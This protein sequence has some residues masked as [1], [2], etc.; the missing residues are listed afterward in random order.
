MPD[1]DKLHGAR[2]VARR[3][4]QRL[5]ESDVRGLLDEELLDRV[6]YAIYARVCD[7]FEV[8]QAQQK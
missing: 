4:I 1:E 5:Y 8:R 2:R 7:M 6:H 3:D